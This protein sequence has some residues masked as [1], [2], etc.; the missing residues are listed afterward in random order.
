MSTKLAIAYVKT[1]VVNRCEPLSEVWWQGRQWAVTAY[2]LEQRDGTY[3]IKADRLVEHLC[4]EQPYAWM[5][6]CR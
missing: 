4:S 1:E 3:T 5:G 6:R 2:G